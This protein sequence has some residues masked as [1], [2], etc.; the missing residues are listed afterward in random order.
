MAEG[1]EQETS[2]AACARLIFT[3]DCLY[4]KAHNKTHLP[5]YTHTLLSRKTEMMSCDSH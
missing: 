5:T 4:F 1:T 2:A 3:L